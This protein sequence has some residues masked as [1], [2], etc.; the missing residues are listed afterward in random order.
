MDR[1]LQAAYSYAVRLLAAREYCTAQLRRKLIARDHADEVVDA[2]VA[3]L[4]QDGYLS[5][6]RFAEQFLDARLRKGESPWLAAQRAREK[7]V[8]E[9][10]L[11]QALAAVEGEYNAHSACR[12][13]LAARD[14][15]GA[16]FADEK[17]WQRQARFL[18]N[19]GF[20]TATILR[21]MK[22]RR[23]PEE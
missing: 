14:P 20:D 1:E 11:Q 3:Q 17:Q 2:V 16:R 12:D 15:Q 6:E 10:A 4:L 21:V 23:Q 7:G 18:R 13:L 19:K 5:E 8:N 22:E 9:S